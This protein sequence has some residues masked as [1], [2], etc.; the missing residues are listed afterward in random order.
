MSSL[1]ENRKPG[2]AFSIK[3]LRNDMAMQ[4]REL[5]TTKHLKFDVVDNEITKK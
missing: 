5:F 2:K 1:S 3:Y 4:M